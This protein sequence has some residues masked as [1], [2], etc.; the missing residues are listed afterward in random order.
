MICVSVPSSYKVPI[1]LHKVGTG[2]GIKA[3]W[4]GNIT[5]VGCNVM[6]LLIGQWPLLTVRPEAVAGDSN[7]VYVVAIVVRINEVGMYGQR[8]PQRY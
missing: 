7:G 6:R 4:L 8:H 2:T 5:G 1:G 3:G